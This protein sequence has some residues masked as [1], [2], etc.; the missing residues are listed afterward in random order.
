MQAVYVYF[1]HLSSIPVAWIN[2]GRL[3]FPLC[4]R[5]RIHVVFGEGIWRCNPCN[6]VMKLGAPF[7]LLDIFKMVGLAL[8]LTEVCSF[9]VL[10]IGAYFNCSSTLKE[11]GSWITSFENTGNLETS[12]FLRWPLICY[13]VFVCLCFPQNRVSKC[14]ITKK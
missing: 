6:S 8:A 9:T 11:L 14:D 3:T 10:W 2:D 5:L 7:V 12:T 1:M 13:V 4:L